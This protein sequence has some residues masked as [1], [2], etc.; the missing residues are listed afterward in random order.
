M[1][2]EFAVR[3]SRPHFMTFSLYHSANPSEQHE[4]VVKDGKLQN[5]LVKWTVRFTNLTDDI[6]M[7]RFPQRTIANLRYY[8]FDTIVSVE[9]DDDHLD[10]VVRVLQPGALQWDE[11]GRRKSDVISRR[12]YLDN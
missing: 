6:D 2:M 11:D 1:A 3:V 10:V 8:V 5:D 7:S 4:P 9:G 12:T